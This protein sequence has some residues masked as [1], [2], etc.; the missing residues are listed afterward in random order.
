[1]RDHIDKYI[2][3]IE[4]DRGMS[5]NTVE[6]YSRDLNDFV[7][8]CERAGGVR[9]PDAVDIRLARRYLAELKRGGRSRTTIARRISALRSFY[10][11]LKKNGI[12]ETNIFFALDTPRLDK[13]IPEHLS[14]EEV[15]ALMDS[16]DTNVT[17]GLRDKAVLELIYSSGMRVSEL[18]ALDLGDIDP[19]RL[20]LRVIGKGRKERIVFVGGAARKAVAE[21]AEKGRSKLGI[22]QDSR[23]LFLNRFGGRLT[24]RGIQRIVEKH[25]NRTAILKKISPHSLRHS[26]ATHLL[27]AG[28]DLRTIQ[29]LLGHASLSTT[30]IYTHLSTERLRKTYDETHPRA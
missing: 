3:H 18:A 22:K 29:E 14:L 30:Q 28:A 15:S 26:F 25:V 9:E 11:Y 5:A 6:A 1:M 8:F 12:V 20:E 7:V 23:A 13:K 27:N 19:N 16:P 24:V 17:D 4:I 21:Y 10:R 2:R